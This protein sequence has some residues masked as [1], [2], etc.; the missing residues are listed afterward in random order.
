VELWQS[1]HSAENTRALE[2]RN[3]IT[4]YCPVSL[5]NG[6]KVKKLISTHSFSCLQFV[7][8]KKKAKD[9]GRC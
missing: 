7:K 3:L 1:L 8:K 5:D 2:R 4:A 9:M 6:H